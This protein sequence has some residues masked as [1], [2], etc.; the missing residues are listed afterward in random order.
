MRDEADLHALLE[1]AR[2][3]AD[4]PKDRS[5]CLKNRR[6]RCGSRRGDRRATRSVSKSARGPRRS[7]VNPPGGGRAARAA[8]RATRH[9]GTADA[10]LARRGHRR[11]DAAGAA[12]AAAGV[13]RPRLRRGVVGA[14]ALLRRHDRLQPQRVSRAAL[15][16]PVADIHFRIS[17]VTSLW[18][19]FLSDYRNI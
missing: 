17:A 9:N 15:A 18:V 3:S 10:P 8:A 11:G 7:P 6:A 4:L 14:L 2:W 13:A 16:P 19:Y 5:S 1:P 12:A